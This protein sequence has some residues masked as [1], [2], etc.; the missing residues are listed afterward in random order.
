MR[1]RHIEVFHAIKQTGSISKAAVLLGISQPAASKVLQHAESSLGFKLF[2]RVKGRLHPTVEADVLHREVVEIQQGLDRLRMLS[3]NLRQ[4]PKGRLRIGCLPSL[5][6]SVMPKAVHDFR[7]RHPAVTCEID[8]N[9]LEMLLS[10]LR[11]RHIDLGVTLLLT[12]PPGIRA[13][14]M[15]D[16]ELVY[17]GP[18]KGGPLRLDDI[19]DASL[20]GVSRLDRIGELVAAQFETLGRLYK[21]TI[22]VQTYYLACAF[23]AAGCGSTIVD[24]FTA[25][26]M[27]REGLFI[28]RILPRMSAQLAVLTHESHVIRGYYT[29]FIEILK[30]SIAARETHDG[31]R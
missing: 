3:A 31:D 30:T 14:I 19:D 6:L 25:R 28:R 2:E 4:M 21:P 23:A 24:E 13:Q 17:F 12:E 7:L 1:L 27:L 11:G 9:H 5:G 26:S 10:Q 20:V 16:V 22:E 15:G 18:Q 29:T 8:T